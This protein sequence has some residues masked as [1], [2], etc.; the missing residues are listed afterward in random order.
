[1]STARITLDNP[2]FSGRFRDLGRGSHFV[3]P[4]TRQTT[5]R[6]ISDI[7]AP[8]PRKAS[9]VKP[10]AQRQAKSQVLQRTTTR[11]VAAKSKR[12]MSKPSGQ[13]VMMAMASMVFLFGIGVA[14]L[15]LKTN[16]HVEAQVQSVANRAEQSDEGVPK[17]E[18]PSQAAMGSYAVDPS[19]PR[20][21]RISKLG[22][23]ARVQRQGLTK[24]GALK[25]PG[26]VY[27]A[28][29]YEN[30][31]KPGQG[32]AM[33]LDGHVAG[34]TAKGVFNRIKDLKAGDVIEIERG[35]GQ[36]FS[37]S[38]AKS[39]V[40]DAASTDMAAA[41]TSVVPGKAALNLI[42]C[43]G[44]YNSSTGEYDQRITVFAVQQ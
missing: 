30:S 10:A 44:K 38:V 16:K 12:K 23:Y 32:G 8:A 17:E 3:K 39:T 1:M 11:P 6:G 21:I 5:V 7:Y 14:V 34:P 33:L 36:K 37:Y 42:T 28:G 43:T 41:L 13:K 31:S 4:R 20:F 27:D 24:T 19:M 40:S 2:A 26:N 35:D 22:V 25:A 9:S 29:W 15:G 18:K